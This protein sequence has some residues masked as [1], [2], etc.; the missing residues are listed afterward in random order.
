MNKKA[1]DLIYEYSAAELEVKCLQDIELIIKKLNEVEHL[2][3]WETFRNKNDLKRQREI[4]SRTFIKDY[5]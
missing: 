2:Y 1:M 5:R 4:L 3:I